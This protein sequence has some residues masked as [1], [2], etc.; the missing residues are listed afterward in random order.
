LITLPY[1]HHHAPRVHHAGTPSVAPSTLSD[2]ADP[3]AN[4]SADASTGWELPVLVILAILTLCVIVGIV[5]H[6]KRQAADDED[7][8]AGDKDPIDGAV[9]TVVATPKTAMK[10]NATFN[11]T[12][13]VRC[14]PSH[15]PVCD[16][17]S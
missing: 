9:A 6:K 14:T 2:D 16:L 8:T 5:L 7:P 13:Q 11:A 12:Y 15:A 1:Y 10:T 4:K 3:S 17:R